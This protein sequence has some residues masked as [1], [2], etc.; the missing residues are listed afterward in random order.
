MENKL[1]FDFKTNQLIIKKIAFID[2]FKGKWKGLE[3]A[4]SIYLKELKQIA[5]IE[6][7]G[8]STRIEGST[9]TNEEVK[10]LLQSVKI[11]SLKSRDEQEVFGY[12]EV[13]NLIVEEF[14]QIILQENEVHYLHK[15]LLKTSTKDDRHRGSYKMLS[16]KV[17]A[18]SPQGSERVIF[19]TT[20]PFLVKEEM[21]NLFEWT[22]SNFEKN[23][24]HPLIVIA[25]FVYEFLSIHPYQDGNGRLSRLLTTLLLL[26]NKYDFMHYASMEIEIEKRKKEYYQALISGQKNRNT[27]K[28]IVN[29]WLIF[30]LDTLE[31]TIQVLEYRF[32]QIKDKTT[33]L[34]ER[35]KKLF[36]FIEENEPVKIQD[37]AIALAEYTIYV[38]RKDIG[39]L[40]KEGLIKKIGK[41]R[42]TIYVLND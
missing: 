16:N 13:L 26:K 29:E 35:Q 9:L 10:K 33:Y 39:H 15:L 17:V 23:E 8:S 19:E 40:Q 37:I 36:K 20:S 7:I 42:A 30:F 22:N 11:S 24:L 2:S 34:N 25:I 1:N 41:S 27:D 6:S 3:V 5:T 4:E 12:Y 38:L 18:K 28:E 21:K 32:E 31:K 14:E